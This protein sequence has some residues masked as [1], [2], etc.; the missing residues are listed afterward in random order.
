MKDPVTAGEPRV[1]T[2]PG[3]EVVTLERRD[4]QVIEVTVRAGDEVASYLLRREADGMSAWDPEGRL[5][6]RVMD[7]N[8]EP[9]VVAGAFAR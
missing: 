7:V 2:G 1:L 6:A 4:E 5:L 3:G 9:M 8:G